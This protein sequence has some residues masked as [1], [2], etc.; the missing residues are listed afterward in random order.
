MHAAFFQ[1]GRNERAEPAEEMVRLLRQGAGHV[2][3]VRRDDIR[4][5]C[6]PARRERERAGGH[7]EMRV[8]HVGPPRPQMPQR[9]EKTREYEKS[10]LENAAR[11]LALAE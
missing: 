7:G 11:L 8:D 4:D 3:E 6:D 2:A 1:I 5:A 9:R 10:H